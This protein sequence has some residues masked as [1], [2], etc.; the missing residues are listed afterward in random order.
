MRISQKFYIPFYWLGDDGIPILAILD[1]FQVIGILPNGDL[2][3]I[4]HGKVNNQLN[5]ATQT[6]AEVVE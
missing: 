3:M 2:M 5:I 1:L 4:H 6:K